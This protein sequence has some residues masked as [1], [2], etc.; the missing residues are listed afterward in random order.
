M[1]EQLKVIVNEEIHPDGME[2]LR[3]QMN[4]VVD[5]DL[6]AKNGQIESAT[7]LLVRS[8]GQ[9]RENLITQA[10][11][12]KVI[13]RYGAGVD[14]ID[15][16]VCQKLGIAVVYAPGLN[17]KSVAE[18][19]IGQAINL[20]RNFIAQDD[21]VRRGDWSRRDHLAGDDI[22]GSKIGLIGLG[23]IGLEVARISRL[24]FEMDVCY[25][26]QVRNKDAEAKLGITYVSLNELLSISDIVS[27]HIP[28]TPSTH[29]LI[30]RRE[31]GRMKRTG[32]L[33][34]FARGGI[35]DEIAL[36]EALQVGVI[37]GAGLDVFLNEPL[38]KSSPLLLA[39][40]TVFSPHTA[41][42]SAGASREISLSVVNDI[43][44]ILSGE[45]PKFLYQPTSL[46]KLV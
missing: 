3:S 15:V 19:A 38:V 27:L 1:I 43:F 45:S 7:A 41:G 13:G 40:N 9:V 8:S 14:N 32:I 36:S 35:V 10:R 23:Q 44:A 25:Y 21:A 39:P 22:R 42:I 17:A 26:D 34:N 29:N 24:G 31:L 28:Y 37:A 33:L 46:I 12:L 18:M 20:R 11:N 16:Q 5:P 4:V 6:G 30:G 2:L